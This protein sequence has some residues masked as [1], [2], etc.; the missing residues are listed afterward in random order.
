MNSLT[1]SPTPQQFADQSTAAL[2][3]VSRGSTT[4]PLP[5]VELDR[6]YTKAVERRRAVLA[7]DKAYT[8]AIIRKLTVISP[9]AKRH[10]KPKAAE[11]LYYY[12]RQ[13]KEQH[14]EAL[15]AQYD[16]GKEY[17]NFLAQKNLRECIS[18]DEVNEMGKR[19]CFHSQDRKKK[20][21]LELTATIYPPPNS[22]K[23]SPEEQKE[24]GARLSQLETRE[25]EMRR[26]ESK[27]LWKPDHSVKR[28]AEELM[29]AA[30][31]LYSG[32]K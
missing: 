16:P 9:G 10:S 11:L 17:R 20:E 6:L 4:R 28:T 7:E 19:L 32:A 2:R 15:R 30:S 26:L 8:D 29:A 12:P 22:R 14:M 1:S 18:P 21:V 25:A 27:Y 13:L 5:P 31:R 23:L 24:C 3:S